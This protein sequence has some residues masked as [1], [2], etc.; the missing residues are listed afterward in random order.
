M[1]ELLPTGREHISFSEL[2]MWLECGWQHKLV[3]IDK[4]STFEPS[5]YSDFGSAVHDACEKYLETRVMDKSVTLERI[6]KFWEERGY[7]DVESWPEFSSAVPDLQYWLDCADAMLDSIP[8]FLE[9]NFPGWEFV[10]AEELLKES[11]DDNDVPYIFKGFVDG[12]IKVP[13]KNGKFKYWI[14]DWK[15]ASTGGWRSD[16]KRDFKT[17]LQLILY[18][19]YWSRK[20]DIPLKDIRCGFI[21]LKRIDPKSRKKSVNRCSIVTVSAGPKT[22]E[23]AKKS[24]RNM[25]S[26]IVEGRHMKNRFA[27]TFCEFFNTEHCLP[28]M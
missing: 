26:S 20:H 14:I 2:R 27:C 19:N 10:A 11:M 28:N 8:E 7:P 16:K 13:E 24:V 22:I 18:K 1:Q 4:L 6:E 9:E 21:L 17:L 23:R 15:T 25:I 3:H 5:I 12:I